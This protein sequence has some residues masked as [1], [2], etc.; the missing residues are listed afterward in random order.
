[1]GPKVPRGDLRGERTLEGLLLHGGLQGG[2]YWA[3]K[4]NLKDEVLSV[5]YF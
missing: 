4:E 2:P 1:M 3:L 5:K